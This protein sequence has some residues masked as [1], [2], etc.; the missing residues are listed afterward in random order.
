[1]HNSPTKWRPLPNL[2]ASI[3]LC[4]DVLAFQ[5]QRLNRKI[6]ETPS[7]NVSCAQI[8]VAPPQRRLNDA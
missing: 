8:I 1:M 4:L 5:F 6:D 3:V 2:Q 7:K